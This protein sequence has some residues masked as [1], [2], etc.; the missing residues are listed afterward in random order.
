MCNPF[1]GYATRGGEIYCIPDKTHA[2]SIIAE[3]FEL[4]DNDVAYYAQNLAKFE[5]TPPADT[6]LWRDLSKWDLKVDENET[7]E[8]FDA[9][10]V[11]AHMERLVRPMFVTDK[12]NWLIGG[13]WIFDGDKASAKGVLGGTIIGVINGANLDGA[14]LTGANLIGA[15]L[16][17]ANLT[18]A[19]LSG[20]TLYGAN[21]YGANLSG[22]NLY[23][24]TIHGGVELPEGWARNADGIITRK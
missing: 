21:L 3:V 16:D 9:E 15:N 20:A 23:G 11:R 12:R 24:A 17:G 7:P 14:N 18:G 2:H 4:R 19:N 5:F 13:C 1:S 8:W 22:A 10:K 6:K